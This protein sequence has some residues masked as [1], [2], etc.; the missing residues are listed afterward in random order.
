MSGKGNCGGESNARRDCPRR[1]FFPRRFSVAA[2]TG[3]PRQTER[4]LKLTKGGSNKLRNSDFKIL[5]CGII[6]VSPF[7]IKMDRTPFFVRWH[8]IGP[9]QQERGAPPPPQNRSG[10]RERDVL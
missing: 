4:A 7:Q 6:F 1:T 3:K 2:S 5:I 10:L 9:D 8:V